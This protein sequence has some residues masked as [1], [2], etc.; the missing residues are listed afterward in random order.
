MPSLLLRARVN[1]AITKRFFNCK[2]PI[3]KGVLSSAIF[4]HLHPAQMARVLSVNVVCT[5]E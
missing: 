2:S 3:V 1:G 5:A 4:P